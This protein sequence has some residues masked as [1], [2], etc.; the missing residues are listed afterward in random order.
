MTV[1]VFIRE[2]LNCSLNHLVQKLLADSFRGKTQ[3]FCC[4]F[5]CSCF[6][7]LGQNKV[8]GNVVA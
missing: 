8:N 7:W 4:G 5:V 6:H 2:S 3:C 1:C